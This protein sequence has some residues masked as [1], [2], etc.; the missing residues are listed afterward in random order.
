V[1][2]ARQRALI[3]SA[4]Q[5]IMDNAIC[6]GVDQGSSAAIIAGARIAADQQQQFT[7]F[8]AARKLRTLEPLRF[9]FR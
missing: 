4:G 5:S 8:L 6:A 2:L 7:V 1:L 3:G 9:S